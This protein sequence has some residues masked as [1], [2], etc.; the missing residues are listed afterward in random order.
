MDYPVRRIQWSNQFV[1]HLYDRR[2][3]AEWDH[4]TELESCAIFT[5]SI[6]TSRL[7]ELEMEPR[8]RP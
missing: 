7:A 4:V 2:F 6:G 5:L 1:G 8:D 3:D